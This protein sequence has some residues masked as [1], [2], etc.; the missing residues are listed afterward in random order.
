MSQRRTGFTL[1]ELL[2]VI[3]IIAILAAILFPVFAKARE[4]ART[5]SCSSNLK[6]IGLALQQYS[7]DNDEKLC[8]NENGVAGVRWCE[9]LSPY[10]K[11]A[12]VWTCPSSTLGPYVPN[13]GPYHYPLQNV[14]RDAARGNLFERGGSGP[15]NLA[16]LDDPAGTVFCGDG[17]GGFQCA[18]LGPADKTT[19]PWRWVPSNG[20]GY[21]QARHMQGY[22]MAFLDGHV[23]WLAFDTLSRLNTNGDW[24]YYTR[25][26]D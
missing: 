22:N 23:K 13:V 12:Q 17:D 15:A 19:E 7:T 5:S 26:M 24:A 18:F 21:Y 10:V 6:Q 9:E 20:Q 8:I 14:Y 4:K 3:A 11:S 1:I 2:V 25:Q 16:A